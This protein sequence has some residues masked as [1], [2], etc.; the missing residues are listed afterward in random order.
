MKIVIMLI[1]A[2][3]VAALS[4]SP[5]LGDTPHTILRLQQALDRHG[6]DSRPFDGIS[7]PKTIGAIKQYCSDR[8]F[9]CDELKPEAV[10]E[11][12]ESEPTPKILSHIDQLLAER[13][14]I[15][16]FTAW[17]GHYLHSRGRKYFLHWSK[18]PS[19]TT[20]D[21]PLVRLNEL[22]WA[23]QYPNTG[24]EYKG[25]REIL[26]S[27]NWGHA[28]E[29][30]QT[31]AVDI[32]S[33]LFVDFMVDQAVQSVQ[34]SESE[35]IFLDWW[36]DRHQGGFS[37][38]QV[39]D[40]RNKLIGGLRAALGENAILLGNVNWYKDQSTIQNLNGVYLEL[41]KEPYYGR[42]N[43]T[44]TR[45]ELYRIEKLL[46]H[47]EKNLRHPRLIALEGWRQTN[48]LSG[49]DRNSSKNRRIAKILT[50]M[51]V[52][53][54]TNGYILYGDNNS[55]TDSGDH[56]HN[57]YD[58]FSFDIGQPTT[59]FI[60]IAD[61]VGYKEHENGVISYNLTNRDFAVELS[62]GLEM[63][64]PSFSGLFCEFSLD[65]VDCLGVD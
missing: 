22:Y 42:A 3:I 60:R 43:T 65:G 17:N 44:Y 58:F 27:T 31:L 55:D 15:N 13:A 29:Y 5:T 24:L 48:N 34:D 36:H 47:Y 46:W 37:S 38:K 53:V 63:V 52:V 64:I 21:V 39:K 12:I 40:A 20:D 28:A 56:A 50:A 33:P 51:S 59:D 45:N 61:G 9:S 16:P 6:Y 8:D 10:L 2:C 30:G 14:T 1:C 41:Y 35:G 32:T 62:T 11:L 19:R 54:P 26:T 57:Y 23:Y 4:S 49:K 18:R 25:V 7:G